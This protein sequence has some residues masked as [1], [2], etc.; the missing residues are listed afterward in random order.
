MYIIDDE[1][2]LGLPFVERVW[3]ALCEGT[4]PLLSIAQSCWQIVV[5]TYDGKMSLTVRGPGDQ[6]H[7][8]GDCPPTE[9]GSA[10]CSTG[11]VSAPSACQKPVNGD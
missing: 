11:H 2:A 4:D 10:F 8:A 5:T 1:A 7:A 3:R 9:S 6:S